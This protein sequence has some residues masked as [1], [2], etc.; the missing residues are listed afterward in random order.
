MRRCKRCGD[1]LHGGYK[2]PQGVLA[3][4]KQRHYRLEEPLPQAGNRL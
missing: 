4:V 1:E 3:V 2:T